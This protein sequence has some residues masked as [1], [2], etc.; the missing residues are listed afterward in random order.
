MRN[1]KMIIFFVIVIMLV[2][3]GIVLSGHWKDKTH[4]RNVELTGNTTLSKEEIFDFAKLSDSLICSNEL[5]LEMIEKRIGKHPNIK[6]V[7]VTRESFVIKIDIS[8]KAPIAAAYNGKDMLLVD[9]KLTIYNFNKENRD[10]DLPVVSGLSSELSPGQYGKNDYANL[11]IAQYI[12][13]KSIKMNRSLELFI[14]EISFSDSLGIILYANE[15]AAPYYFIDYDS[16]IPKDKVSA[17]INIKDINNPALRNEIDL[18]LFLLN[19]FIKQV[20]V[21]KPN[22]SIAYVDMRY[23]NMIVV[24]NNNFH[25]KG[26]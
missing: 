13:S 4:I 5:T 9:D 11:K 21:Y 8:E 22:N 2:C 23:N 3:S 7:S 12:I 18:K 26:L 19:N 20:R 10:I 6:K 17:A 14:S 15:D 16:I 1:Y 24:K 25:T